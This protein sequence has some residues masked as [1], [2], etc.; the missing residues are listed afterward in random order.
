MFSGMEVVVSINP[1]LPYWILVKNCIFLNS[2]TPLAFHCLSFKQLPIHIRPFTYTAEKNQWLYTL[3][4][5]ATTAALAVTDWA[6]N[7]VLP[8]KLNWI[9]ILLYGNDMCNLYESLQ[10]WLLSRKPEIIL[11]SHEVGLINDNAF[12]LLYPSYISQ[13]SDL[14]FRACSH[15]GGEPQV[16]EVTRLAVVENWPAFT[17]KR[18]TPGSRGD[19]TRCCCVVARHVNRENGVWM[20]HF[21][22]QCSF[23]LIICSH[24]NISV[25]WLFTVTFDD[26]KP[27]KPLPKTVNCNLNSIPAR[28][29][30]PPW[31][32]YMA[33]CHPGW[34]G[35]PTW[36]TGQPV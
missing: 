7:G 34:Q 22:G 14:P 31:V 23:P 15:G 19:V 16:G 25:L 4:R 20:T 30:T 5:G 12:L 1:H 26:T 2:P 10:K 8:G 36:Q 17:C 11:L 3:P 24:C 35:Y 18:T 32:V 9:K 29:V 21:C 33:K 6:D 27:R 28:R 13:N